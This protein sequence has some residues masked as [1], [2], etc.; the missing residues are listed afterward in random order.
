MKNPRKEPK[1]EILLKVKKN[2]EKF[3]TNYNLKPDFFYAR[4]VFRKMNCFY[5]QKFREFF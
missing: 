5:G 1:N 3:D 2:V 4:T